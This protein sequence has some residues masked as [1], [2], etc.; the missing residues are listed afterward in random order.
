MIDSPFRRLRLLTGRTVSDV[1]ALSNLSRQAVTNVEAGMYPTTPITANRTITVLCRNA[2]VDAR[3]ILQDEYG[4]PSLDGAMTLWRKQRRRMSELDDAPP[5]SL[6]EMIE[7]Y[8][9]PGAFCRSLC[10]PTSAIYHT[11]YGRGGPVPD[12]IREA[13]TDAGYRYAKMMQ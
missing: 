5:M 3:K 9:N 12:V 4:S 10:I 1:A 8:P 6:T 2:N 11:V 7:S 13:L